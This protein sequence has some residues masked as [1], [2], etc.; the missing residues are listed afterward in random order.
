LILRNWATFSSEDHTMFH[1][2]AVLGM[3]GVL[4]LGLGLIPALAASERNDEPSALEKDSKGWIDMLATAGSALDGWTRKPIPA[5]GKL[6][7]QSQWSLDPASG[8]LACKGD[9]GHE[10]LRLDQVLTDYIFHVEWRFSPVPGKHGYNSGVYVRNS[11][12]G[13]MWHQAQCGDASGGYLFGATLAAYA[14]QP[15]NLRK[16]VHEQRVRPSGE[17]NTYEL[18]CKGRNITLW[19]NGAVTCQWKACGV[20]RGY[21][22]LEAE[23]WRIEFRNVKIKL[24]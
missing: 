13:R 12:D 14:M 21:V 7:S 5:D 18:T 1:S 19:V 9:G 2:R 22:G 8:V 4:L 23:G 17:W 20:P 24:L 11:S 16:D 3:T 6:N 15:F 10:W